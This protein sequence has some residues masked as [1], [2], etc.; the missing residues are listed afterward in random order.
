MS[1]DLFCPLAGEKC[2]HLKDGKCETRGMCE[3]EAKERNK[4]TLAAHMSET[5]RYLEAGLVPCEC[6]Q[7]MSPDELKLHRDVLESC[8]EV[9]VG[10]PKN[11]EKIPQHNPPICRQ[12][13]FIAKSPEI[14]GP[15]V[16]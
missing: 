9:A 14:N 8:S 5:C 13:T 12:N 6:G 10:R 11:L 7:W 15:R 2:D 3:S 16:G 1:S 4:S